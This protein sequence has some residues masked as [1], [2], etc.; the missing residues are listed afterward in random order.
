M[1]AWEL[2]PMQVE[3]RESKEGNWFRVE[4][5]PGGP[6]TLGMATFLEALITSW[7]GNVIT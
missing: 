4:S 6:H 2:D 7:N 3:S 1:S 5:T